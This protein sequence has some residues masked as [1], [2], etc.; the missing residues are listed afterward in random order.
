LALLTSP[1]HSDGRQSEKTPG[2]DQAKAAASAAEAFGREAP[3]DEPGEVKKLEQEI[4][5]LEAEA[6]K[7]RA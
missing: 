3:D 2:S 1:L 7:L 4:A 5:A 6:A